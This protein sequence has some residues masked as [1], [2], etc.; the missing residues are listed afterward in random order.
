MKQNVVGWF[1]I[2]VDDID[3]AKVFYESVFQVTLSDLAVPGG[4]AGMKMLTF[5]MDAFDAPGATGALVK[6]E[7]YGP[8]SGGTIIYFNSED[9]AIEAARV[10]AAGGVVLKPKESIGE[11]GFIALF[12]DSEGNVIGI[13]S[14]K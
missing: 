8:V 5:P 12:K 7:G 11:H 6:M 3:R 2:Y 10:E 4:E 13:H 14:M 1:E 9:C